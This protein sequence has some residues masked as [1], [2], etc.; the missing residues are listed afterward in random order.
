MLVCMCILVIIKLDKFIK[1]QKL[2]TFSPCAHVT[3]VTG[4][5]AKGFASL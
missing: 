2:H 5:K 1:M 4:N 3:Y